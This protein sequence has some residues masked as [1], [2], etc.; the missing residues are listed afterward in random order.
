MGGLS[1][2]QS[3]SGL[4]AHDL[5]LPGLVGGD[6]SPFS[7]VI[8]AGLSLGPQFGDRALLHVLSQSLGLSIFDAVED[9]AVVVGVLTLLGNQDLVPW[10]TM[11]LTEADDV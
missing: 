5:V 2:S 11:S 1:H 10:A 7:V 4:D 3:L 8:L 9:E 6:D